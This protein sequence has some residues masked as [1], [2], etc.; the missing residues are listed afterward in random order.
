MLMAI[1]HEVSGNVIAV[2]VMSGCG[3]ETTTVSNV[4]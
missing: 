3:L 1:L 4:V 2:Y